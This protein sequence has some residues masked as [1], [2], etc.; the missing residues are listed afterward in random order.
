MLQ[1]PITGPVGPDFMALPRADRRAIY[2]R[3]EQSEQY[4]LNV[5][6]ALYYVSL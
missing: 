3:A 1:K 4:H 5:L 2:A 6:K